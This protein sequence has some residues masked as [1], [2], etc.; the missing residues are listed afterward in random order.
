MLQPLSDTISTEAAPE[1]HDEEGEAANIPQPDTIPSTE[2]PTELDSSA[3]VVASAGIK[4]HTDRVAVIIED[5]PLG[6]LVP[7]ICEL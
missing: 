5:R 3:S 2:G 4:R 6:N 7:V 1:V